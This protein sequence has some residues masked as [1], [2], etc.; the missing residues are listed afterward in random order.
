MKKSFCRQDSKI[1]AKE[2][3]LQAKLGRTVREYG[4]LDCGIIVALSGGAD[5]HALLHALLPVCRNAGVPVMCAHVNHMLRGADADADEAF[6]R[7]ICAGLGVPIEVLRTDVAAIARE[8]GLGFE[9][10]ARDVR[11]AFFAELCEKH[12]QYKRIATAHTASDNAETVLFNLARGGGIRGLCGIPP[13]RGNIVRPLVCVTRAEVEDYCRQNSLEYVIDCT[14]ADTEYSRNYIRAEI[15]PRL[16][17]LYH[18]FAEAASRMSRNLRRDC[19]FLEAEAKKA[20]A[21]LYSDG[22]S[23]DALRALHPAVA[24]RVLMLAFESETGRKAESVHLDAVLEKLGEGSKPFSLY[25]PGDTVVRCEQGRLIF[26]KETEAPE[27]YRIELGEGENVLPDGSVLLVLP[28]EGE[29]I[30]HPSHKVYN[31]S[32]FARVCSDT[33]KKGVF[34]RSRECGDAYR[35]GGM[36]RK[37]KKLLNATR[38]TV[39]ERDMLPVVCD[40]EGILWVPGFAVRDGAGAK[41]GEKCHIIY[42]IEAKAARMEDVNDQHQR[43]S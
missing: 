16:D 24:V 19:D 10:A 20:F 7:R 27:P 3:I 34:A 26:I 14:N 41:K 37:L 22:F 40:G 17:T 21:E 30:T 29:K 18:G 15:I 31:L 11:Y 35:F 42:Y 6:C 43:R 28:D 38:L 25:M 5:S 32:I 36:T 13:V 4:M 39:R 33:I 12:P 8:R 9:E 1:T 2:H 23:A